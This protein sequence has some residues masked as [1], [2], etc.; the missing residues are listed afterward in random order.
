MKCGGAG[1]QFLQKIG[2]SSSETAKSVED[3][4]K[5]IFKDLSLGGFLLKVVSTDQ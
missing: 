1:K 3:F 5:L 4:Q 2:N